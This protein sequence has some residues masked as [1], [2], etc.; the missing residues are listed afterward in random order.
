[1]AVGTIIGGATALASA[2]T[3]AIGSAAQNKKA[4]NLLDTQRAENK[5]WYDM[6]KAEQY[7]QRSDF[8]AIL[9]K[10]KE[11]LDEQYANARGV[12]AVAGGTDESVALQKKVA[13]QS[14][15]DTMTNVAG[16]ASAYKDN[17][18]AQYRQTDQALAN[19]QA[20]TYA[21]QANNIAQAAGQGI[22]AGLNLIASDALAGKKPNG[23]PETKTV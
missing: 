5:A 7:T 23:D 19:Q 11:L 10:Q 22:T 14:L 3:G 13:N 20:A 8:Q 21:N 17:L 9:K 18:D 15:S 16:Q 6:K 1:M 4:R 12:N 2:I